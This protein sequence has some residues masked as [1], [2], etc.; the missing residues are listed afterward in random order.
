MAEQ[1][2]LVSIIALVLVIVL[3]FAVLILYIIYF[4]NRDISSEYGA[5][6]DYV[7]VS[8][9]ATEIRPTGHQ[10]LSANGG[11]NSR[12]TNPDFLYIGRPKNVPYVRRIFIVYN[13]SNTN[14]LELR[15][16]GID[17]E[18]DQGGTINIDQQTGMLFFWKNN[19]TLIPVVVGNQIQN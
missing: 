15:G 13:R 5:Q 4:L 9:T 11:S 8:D 3:M 12:G 6:W 1:P 10:V 18:C 16:D 2:S 14:Q 7:N 17:F 19:D